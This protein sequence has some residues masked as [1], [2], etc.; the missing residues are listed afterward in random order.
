MDFLMW[1]LKELCYGELLFLTLLGAKGGMDGFRGPWSQET[2]TLRQYLHRLAWKSEISEVW[3]ET[4][5][6][7]WLEEEGKQHLSGSWGITR[8]NMQIKEWEEY[9][10]WS[11]N[12]KIAA[13]PKCRVSSRN[14]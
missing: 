9:S 13:K 5:S 3:E 8:I 12:N 6:L 2:Y 11:K 4:E 10:K 14:K 1:F 7:V